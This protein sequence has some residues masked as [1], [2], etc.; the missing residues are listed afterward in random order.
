[1]YD[2]AILF[3]DGRFHMQNVSF[4]IPDGYYLD[5]DYDEPLGNVTIELISPDKKHRVSLLVS[6]VEIPLKEFLIDLVKDIGTHIL[7][8]PEAITVGG[9][10]GYYTIYESSRKLYAEAIFDLEGSKDYN[11]FQLVFIFPQDYDI[12]D[13]TQ[14]QDFLRIAQT[15]RKEEPQ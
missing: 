13:F 4:C 1:M 6:F 5:T 14:S 11:A 7:C 2:T 12:S 3:K 10:H 9:L 8:A 15:I